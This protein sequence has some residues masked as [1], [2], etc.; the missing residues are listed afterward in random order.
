M[1]KNIQIVAFDNPNPPDYGGA[2]EIY[3]KLTALRDLGISI[4]LHLFEYGKRKNFEAIEQICNRVFK[5]KRD[6][7][8]KNVFSRIPFIVKSRESNLLLENL[9]KSTAPI[10][11]EGIHCCSYLEHEQLKNHFKIVRTHN[12][13]HEYYLGLYKSSK[14]LLKKIYYKLEAKKLKKFESVLRGSDL[15]L[16][17]SKKDAVYFKKYANTI[18]IPPFSERYSEVHNTEPYVLFHGN[19]SVEENIN[20]LIKLIENVFSKLNLRV[21][22]AGKD[23]SKAITMVI[24]KYKNIKLIPNPGKIKMDSLIENARCHVFYTDQ[25]TGVKLSLVHAILT[26]GHIIMNSKMLFDSDFEQEIEVV[27]DWDKMH[28]TIEKCF[29]KENAKPRPGLRKL[30]DNELNLLRFL[31]EVESKNN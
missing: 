3:Y 24:K 21:C 8:F 14:S 9:A 6:M 4:D 5:Y 1:I 2:V 29:D 11:F 28:Q 30:F 19:L 15:I 17:L 26:S 7:A 16:S 12:I 10:L 13:E 27:D 23:P 18:W 31:K 25:N 20:A 22:I